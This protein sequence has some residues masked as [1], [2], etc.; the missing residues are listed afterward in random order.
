MP[1]GRPGPVPDLLDA[2]ATAG[3]VPRD[4]L[5]RWLDDLLRVLDLPQAAR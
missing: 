3:F 5:R 4:E 1:A 2:G